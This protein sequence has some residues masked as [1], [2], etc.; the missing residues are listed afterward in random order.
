MSKLSEFMLITWCLE[1][2]SLV[3]HHYLDSGVHQQR[4]GNGSSSRS[5]TGNIW[6]KLIVM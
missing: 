6:V 1:T 4:R 2:N 5:L 3:Y